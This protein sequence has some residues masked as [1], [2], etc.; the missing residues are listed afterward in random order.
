MKIIG[1][2]P[3]GPGGRPL[4][5]STAIE[6]GGLVYL[7]GQ[8]AL[9][10]GALVG[11][12]V[13]EQCDTVLDNIETILAGDGLGLDNVFKLTIWLVDAGSFAE[14]NACYA[15]RIAPPYPVRST[16]ISGLA[17]PGALI[18]IEAVAARD[19]QRSSR[20]STGQA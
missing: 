10:D 17:L 20:A 9:R 18:E 7:S 15:R 11:S 13:A 6:I 12:T 5:L 19:H 2:P 4:P 1:Q 14:F 8:L 3:T 16:V